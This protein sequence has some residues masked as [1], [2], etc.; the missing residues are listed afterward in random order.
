MTQVTKAQLEAVVARLNRL[1]DSP[2]EPYALV[3]GK[4]E[5]Q[6]GCYHLDGAYGG[7]KLARMCEGGGSAD[8]LPTGYVS[9]RSLYD[10]IYIYV[11][12]VEDG[13]KMGREK[14]AA[15]N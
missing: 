4:Y 5:P 6:A 11:I 14:N 9:R 15:E 3:E 7:W 13:L 10:A 1:T 2:S 12:G 8:I